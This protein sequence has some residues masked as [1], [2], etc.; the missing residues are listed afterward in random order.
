[1]RWGIAVVLAGSI[2]VAR[3]DERPRL[4]TFTSSAPGWA[5]DCTVDLIEIGDGAFSV[6]VACRGSE[7]LILER[8][9][10]RSGSLSGTV[11]SFDGATRMLVWRTNKYA[12]DIYSCTSTAELDPAA[13]CKA[14]IHTVEHSMIVRRGVAAFTRPKS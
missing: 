1:M 2:A 5:K 7:E 9:A 10:K 4:E 11:T 14:L 6:A 3:A 13:R 8:R 12:T